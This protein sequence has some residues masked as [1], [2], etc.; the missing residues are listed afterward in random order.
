[1]TTC[2]VLYLSDSPKG[3]KFEKNFPLRLLWLLW[4]IDF[5]HPGPDGQICFRPVWTRAEVF[6]KGV[7]QRCL[8]GD[9]DHQNLQPRLQILIVH[10][11]SLNLRGFMLLI[12]RAGLLQMLT[13]LHCKITEIHS[14]SKITR[15]S[16]ISWQYRLA[17]NVRILTR[18]D[19]RRWEESKK[20]MSRKR[21]G[22]VHSG[23]KLGAVSTK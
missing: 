9:K 6:G 19:I 3:L 14:K 17:W 11:V 16:S 7:W 8:T 12:K 5:F 20:W 18:F 2:R 21:G 22:G 23:A 4:S 10:A 13:W 1:M 15:S